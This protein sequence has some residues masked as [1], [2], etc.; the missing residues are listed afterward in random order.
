MLNKLY[1][2]PGHSFVSRPFLAK[3]TP[4]PVVSKASAQP[5]SANMIIPTHSNDVDPNTAVA[6]EMSK[7]GKK[8][9]VM[10][11]VMGL[12][13]Y[14][15]LS[16]AQHQQYTDIIGR[17]PSYTLIYR[18]WDDPRLN[19]ESCQ[20]VNVTVKAYNK[21]TPEDEVN[22]IFNFRTATSLMTDKD[23][24]CIPN[25]IETNLLG[26]DWE[27]KTL[28]VLPLKEV[29]QDTY[30]FWPEFKSKLFPFP[31][32]IADR[33]GIAYIEK[34]YTHPD[35]PI[36][37]SIIGDPQ[38]PYIPM[39][40]QQCPTNPPDISAPDYP[41]NCFY[42]PADDAHPAGPP[43]DIL[44]VYHMAVSASCP[45][46]INKGHTFFNGAAWSWDTK[47]LTKNLLATDHYRKY[48]YHIAYVYG[49]PLYNYFTQGAYEIIESNQSPIALPTDGIRLF[50]DNILCVGKRSS[51]N[52]NDNENAPP[53]LLNPDSK[54]EF[55][56]I[57]FYGDGKVSSAGNRQTGFDRNE[58]LRRTILHEMG[59]ALLSAQNSDHCANNM[60]IMSSWVEDWTLHGFGDEGSCTHSAEGSKNIRE[61]GVI[62]N[63]VH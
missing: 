15:S 32:Q 17:P 45:A 62:H 19:I 52:L 48:Q 50:C 63:S 29:A 24:D 44:V 61:A 18:H 3:T 27:K 28:F 11:R 21:N 47:G 22:F 60:C 42:D 13:V 2:E 37:I 54:V 40:K 43:C 5:P 56:P 31:A 25:D 57:T 4:N 55:N 36:E 39:R 33:P 30:E 53:Y 10:M 9:V 1:E 14:N 51:M 59:H 7:A 38:H 16:P 12:E 6:I 41:L 26:T 46:N 34:L 49:V 20:Q 58:V 23:G 8:I 35:V